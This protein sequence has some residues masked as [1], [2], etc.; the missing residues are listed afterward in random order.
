MLGVAAAAVVFDRFTAVPLFLAAAIALP[1]LGAWF[2]LK[3]ARRTAPVD[4]RAGQR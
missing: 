4:A 3:L 1:L 2:A